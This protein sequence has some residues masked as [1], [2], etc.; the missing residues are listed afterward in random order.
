MPAATT[1]APAPGGSAHPS[2]SLAFPEG[3]YEYTEVLDTNVLQITAN[4]VERVINI[5]PGGFLRGVSLYVSSASGVL[6]PGVLQGDMPWCV[7]YSATIESIDGTSIK[8]PMG[9]YAIYL[10]QKFMR[11]WDGDPATD[12]VFTNSVNPAFRIRFF[13]ESRATLGVVPN[14]DA[15]AQYR[16]RYTVNN[17]ANT[18][19][20]A[21]TTAPTLTI[22]T[23]S[24]IYAQPPA[25]SLMGAPIQQVPDGVGVQRFTS[26]QVD[27][28][29]SANSTLKLNRVG[30][31]IRTLILVFRDATANQVRTD[32]TTDPIRWRIDNTQ[33]LYE[34][35][36]RRDYE[37]NRFW[38]QYRMSTAPATATVPVIANVRPT[39]VYVFPRWHDPGSMTGQ[40]WL[41]TT[42]ATFVQWEF[43]GAVASGTVEQIVEDLAP[44]GPVPAYLNGI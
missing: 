26:H 8:Y 17:V 36:T 11:P 32:L 28:T 31:L 16:L 20:T 7:I 37:M 13:I 22:V 2:P 30:N 38:S 14:T 29:S 5:T 42:E 4:T 34:Q 19:S 39:G 12:A 24:E 10:E 21:P 44:A 40:W 41:E 25:T 33:L 1:T 3:T 18:F 23:C 6:G 27:V 35:R 9:G 15:R 43:T